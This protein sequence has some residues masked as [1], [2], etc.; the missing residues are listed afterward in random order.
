MDVRTVP[1]DKVSCGV[2]CRK[3][4]LPSANNLIGSLVTGPM[5]F[6]SHLQLK[7]HSPKRDV[8][9]LVAQFNKSNRTPDR[10]NRQRGN[11][12]SLNYRT[13]LIKASRRLLFVPLHHLTKSCC[14]AYGVCTHASTI[15]QRTT[16]SVVKKRTH[17]EN[18]N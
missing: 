16:H 17:R 7:Q 18:N 12:T 13:I 5:L 1:I 6:A 4:V 2:A 14:I 15:S 9:N 11:H 3:T 10:M 8:L